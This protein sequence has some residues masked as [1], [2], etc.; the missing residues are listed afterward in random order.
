MSLPFPLLRIFLEELSSLT[1]SL[2]LTN[3]SL[4]K[5]PLCF[6]HSIPA[7]HNCPP[8]APAISLE[9]NPMSTSRSLLLGPLSSIDCCGPFPPWNSLPWLSYFLASFDSFWSSSY[10][11]GYLLL[12]SSFS[13]LFF[14]YPCPINTNSIIASTF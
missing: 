2:L 14:D 6:L 9:L 12:A 11:S 1:H 8:K 5:S 13:V 3:T 10:L 7:L 4:P